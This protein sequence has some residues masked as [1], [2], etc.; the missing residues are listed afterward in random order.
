MSQITK[1]YQKYTLLEN[2]ALKK[3]FS[4]FWKF[5]FSGMIDL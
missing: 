1:I 4:Y 5:D 2:K 3:Y